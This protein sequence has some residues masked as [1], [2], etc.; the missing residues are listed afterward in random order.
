MSDSWHGGKGSKPRKVNK[1]I[2]DE[3]YDRIF[4]NKKNTNK[5]TPPGVSSDEITQPKKG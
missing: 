4:G 1:A 5:N 2:Y 3:N